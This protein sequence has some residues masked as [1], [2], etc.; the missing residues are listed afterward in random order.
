MRRVDFQEIYK[1]LSLDMRSIEA[2][3]EKYPNI[4]IDTLQAIYRRKFQYETMRN[5]GTLTRITTPEDILTE[6]LEAKSIKTIAASCKVP[7]CALA[8]FILK[9]LPGENAASVLKSPNTCTH[10]DLRQIL[11]REIDASTDP[12]HPDWDATRRDH[13]DSM[14]GELAKLLDAFNVPYFRED[15]L[16]KMGFPKTP[17][18]KLAFPVAIHSDVICWVESK[19]VFGEDHGHADYAASQYR[20]YVNRFGP[21]AVVYWHGFIDELAGMSKQEGVILLDGTTLAKAFS[22]LTFI[23]S[24]NNLSPFVTLNHQNTFEENVGTDSSQLLGRISGHVKGHSGKSAGD[25]DA[26]GHAGL[27]HRREPDRADGAVGDVPTGTAEP[28]E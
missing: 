10:L 11:S 6:C 14:E 8:R 18:F 15:H 4:P 25:D 24:G 23:A 3:V 7:V 28:G 2:A 1:I 5:I 17:D 26:A 19:A 20:P 13:G 9:A 27:A 16:R 12:S 21:G 22:S